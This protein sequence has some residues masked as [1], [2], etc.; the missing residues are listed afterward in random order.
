MDNSKDKIYLTIKAY[1]GLFLASMFVI[2]MIFGFI[3]WGWS[4]SNWYWSIRLIH[5]AISAYI[6]HYYHSIFITIFS[7]ETEEDNNFFYDASK[8]YDD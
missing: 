1:L 7:Q 3:A 4:M 6:A 5:V 2:Y 8:R